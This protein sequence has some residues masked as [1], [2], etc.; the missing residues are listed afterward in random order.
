VIGEERNEDTAWH[1]PEPREATAEITG[2]MAV[3]KGV[4]VG[5]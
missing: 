1:H 4:Q 2:R 3:W 5:E